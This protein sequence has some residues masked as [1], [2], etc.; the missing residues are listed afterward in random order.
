M[1]KL[2][3]SMQKEVAYNWKKR[4]TIIKENLYLNDTKNIR[5]IEDIEN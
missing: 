3:D 5:I 1:D 4:H 2:S